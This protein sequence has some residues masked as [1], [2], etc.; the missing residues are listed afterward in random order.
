MHRFLMAS[1]TL[2]SLIALA[3]LG[4]VLLAIPINVNGYAVPLWLSVVPIVVSGSLAIW[5]FRLAK[6]GGAAA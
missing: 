2:F 6:T 1:G 5:A 4:R 3:W